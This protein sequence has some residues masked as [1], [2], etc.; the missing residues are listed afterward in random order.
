M[1]HSDTVDSIKTYPIRCLPDLVGGEG[2]YI[3]KPI[4]G[5]VERSRILTVDFVTVT[6]RCCLFLTASRAYC[7]GFSA[8]QLHRQPMQANFGLRLMKTRSGKLK[9][10]EQYCYKSIAMS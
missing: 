3:Q 1:G 6:V 9:L 8:C 2:P 7:R 5:G 10:S 4:K